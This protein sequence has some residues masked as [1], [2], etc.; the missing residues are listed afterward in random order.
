MNPKLIVST[1]KGAIIV[2]STKNGTVKAHIEWDK[3]FGQKMTKSLFSAQQYVDS[4]VLRYCDPLVP[5]D[6]GS[7]KLSGQLGT[8]IGDGEVIYIAPYAA[9]MYFNPQ[10]NFRGAPNRGAYWFERMK[11]SHR[12]AILR[13]AMAITAKDW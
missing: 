1:P 8:T 9:R 13:G 2:T 11:V 6:T 3:G 10:Y 5:F 12:D 4:E 7:L